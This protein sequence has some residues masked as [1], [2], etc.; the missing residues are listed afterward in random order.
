MRANLSTAVSACDIWGFKLPWAVA[1]SDTCPGQPF[2]P[3]PQSMRQ[4]SGRTTEKVEGW[5]ENARRETVQQKI[6]EG[7]TVVLFSSPNT[8]LLLSLS[9]LTLFTFLF[10]SGKI[11]WFRK[12]KQST[13]LIFLACKLVSK[14]YEIFVSL[15]SYSGCTVVKWWYQMVIPPYGEV[16]WGTKYWDHNENLGI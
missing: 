3:P 11:V 6:R 5:K 8:L 4:L 7:R 15:F 10:I 9:E 16:H 13:I 2:D 12:S 14:F 1:L